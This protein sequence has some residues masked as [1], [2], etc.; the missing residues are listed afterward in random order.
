MIMKKIDKFMAFLMTDVIDRN[1]DIQES[2][3]SEVYKVGY[4]EATDEILKLMAEI[5]EQ[6]KNERED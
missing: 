2:E 6:V 1:H 5:F 3:E 4:Q